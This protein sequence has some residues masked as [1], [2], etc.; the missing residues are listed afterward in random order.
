MAAM[1]ENFPENKDYLAAGLFY[2]KNS[3]CFPIGAVLQ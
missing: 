2:E 1:R 3:P